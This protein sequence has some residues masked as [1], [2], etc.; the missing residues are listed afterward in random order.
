MLCLSGTKTWR[1]QLHNYR[2][3]AGLLAIA[4]GYFS[5][6]Y[7]GHEA[8]KTLLFCKDVWE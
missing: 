5:N 2:G 1:I 7:F 6:A 8:I 3:A 4:A